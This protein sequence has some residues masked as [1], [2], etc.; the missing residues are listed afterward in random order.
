MRS[1]RSISHSFMP[2]ELGNASGVT[3]LRRRTGFQQVEQPLLARYQVRQLTLHRAA[4][5]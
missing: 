4:F 3:L 2:T 1:L 5:P